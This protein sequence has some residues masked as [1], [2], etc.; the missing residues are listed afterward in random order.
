VVDLCR[1]LS[2]FRKAYFLLEKVL[3]WTKDIF[4]LEAM[5]WSK[6][7]LNDGLDLQTQLLASQDVSWWTGVVW[8]IVMF[9][10][11]VWTLILTAPIHCRGSI[12]ERG[13]MESPEARLVKLSRWD[14]LVLVLKS[15]HYCKGFVVMW[16]YININ[17]Q[18]LSFGWIIPL[19]CFCV[20]SR[21]LV[22]MQ[23]FMKD[24]MCCCLL[25]S[26]PNIWVKN[27]S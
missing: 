26:V 27:R 23:L 8:I 20:T 24:K 17:M 15:K 22:K 10:S 2:W 5:V 1:C 19:R 7:C 3:V 11:A 14:V 6:K 13:V 9:L 21:C 18:M 4:Q 12:A 25:S 16:C